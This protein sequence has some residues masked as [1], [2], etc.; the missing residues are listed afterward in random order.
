MAPISFSTIRPPPLSVNSRCA[1]AS[2]SPSHLVLYG[3]QH[4]QQHSATC[5]RAIKGRPWLLGAFLHGLVLTRSLS[6]DCPALRHLYWGF[7]GPIK[8]LCLAPFLLRS[9]GPLRY[10]LRCNCTGRLGGGEGC[11]GSTFLPPAV[12]P[13]LTLSGLTGLPGE[14]SKK[15]ARWVT[16]RNR[17]CQRQTW[18]SLTRPSPVRHP[19]VRHLDLLT[20]QKPICPPPFP[21][22]S[23]SPFAVRQV[24]SF[25]TASIKLPM[26]GAPLS[27]SS[28][29][30]WRRGLLARYP[31]SGALF[32]S[33]ALFI[34]RPHSHV[35]SRCSALALARPSGAV[36][37]H[38]AFSSGWKMPPVSHPPRRNRVD[39]S[40]RVSRHDDG[41]SPLSTSALFQSLVGAL[42]DKD[43]QWMVQ[44]ASS[45]L[46]LQSTPVS[47][48]TL[49]QDP[50]PSLVVVPT[51]R[52]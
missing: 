44:P 5:C 27:A 3:S 7:R 35:M 26:R 8:C 42:P 25:L 19:I 47:Q 50:R 39:G 18:P 15:E 17:I 37:F 49:P 21:T 43:R 41:R 24:V 32:S 38:P 29:P 52:W 11:V 1:T 14:R 9:S 36:K 6:L 4:T 40:P 20:R 48:A 31:P 16:S 46:N 22:L 2:H 12:Q 28:P 30:P 13:D 23:T 45:H 33:C 34:L 10:N 51:L